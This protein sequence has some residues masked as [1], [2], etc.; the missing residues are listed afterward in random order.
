MHGRGILGIQWLMCLGE[1]DGLGESYELINV[2]KTSVHVGYL[3]IVQVINKINSYLENECRSHHYADES[4]DQGVGE[5]K[6]HRCA[7]YARSI[8]MCSTDGSVSQAP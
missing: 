8:G 3:S 4:R 2:V 7:R 1:I 6:C 5:R